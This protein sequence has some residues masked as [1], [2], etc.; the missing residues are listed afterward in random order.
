[1]SV[2]EEI[3]LENTSM[4]GKAE[5]TLTSGLAVGEGF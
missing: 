5:L 1:M 2:R 4:F 3:S